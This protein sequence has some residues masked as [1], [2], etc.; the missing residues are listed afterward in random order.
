MGVF[1]VTRHVGFYLPNQGLNL[2]PLHWKG[3]SWEMTFKSSLSFCG[4]NIRGSSL[5]GQSGKL[6]TALAWEPDPS[7]RG[8]GPMRCR[9]LTNIPCLYPR[10]SQMV[11]QIPSFGGHDHPC[12]RTA[13]VS[14]IPMSGDM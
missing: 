5:S 1:F 11:P 9:M 7:L 6:G 4:C 13:A 8:G 3:K 2:H 10:M 14:E 12:M